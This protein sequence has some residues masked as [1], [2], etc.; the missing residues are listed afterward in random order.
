MTDSGDGRDPF[1]RERAAILILAALMLMSIVSIAFYNLDRHPA[2][3][4]PE[5]SLLDHIAD[6]PTPSIMAHDPVAYATLEHVRGP[7]TPQSITLDHWPPRGW[8]FAFGQTLDFSHELQ[9]IDRHSVWSLWTPPNLDGWP[10]LD[11]ALI[12]LMDDRQRFTSCPRQSPELFECPTMDE[13]PITAVD[14]TV[15]GA[16]D[17]CISAPTP[18]EGRLVFRFPHVLP[19]DEEGQ[20]LHL[21]TAFDDDAPPDSANI[22]LGV[23]AGAERF[24]HHHRLHR[25]WQRRALPP[26]TYP[27]ELTLQIGADHSSDHFCFR[28]QRQ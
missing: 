11:H 17:R 4:P 20:R 7:D 25:G 27:V 23:I 8:L 18:D 10:H 12:D 9:L 14:V 28:F 21:L 22:H 19:V 6:G 15:A 3:P 1:S 16:T 2:F 13:S 26:K 24:D 5:P